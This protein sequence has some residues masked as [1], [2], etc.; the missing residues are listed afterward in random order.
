MISCKGLDK[1]ILRHDLYAAVNRYT[2]S[3]DETEMHD[4]CRD[5]YLMYLIITKSQ[6]G[7]ALWLKIQEHLGEA[8][9]MN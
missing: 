9:P 3:G 6:P 5:Q 7:D 2:I 1:H 8:L 4:L